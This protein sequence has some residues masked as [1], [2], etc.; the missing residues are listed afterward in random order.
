MGRDKEGH[1]VTIRWA[2]HLEEIT[3]LCVTQLQDTER[4]KLK[5]LKGRIDRGP[6]PWPSG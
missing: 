4:K 2:V 6:A 5:E 3:I 1:F